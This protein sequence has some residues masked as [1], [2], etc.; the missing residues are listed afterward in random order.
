MEKQMATRAHKAMMK[1]NEWAPGSSGNLFAPVEYGTEVHG[2]W[3]KSSAL[4]NVAKAGLGLG[5]AAAL[6]YV[7]RT[8]GGERR[9]EQE[10]PAA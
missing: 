8:P 6:V 7:L 10:I 4:G 9:R 3:K 2:G 5:L 1:R